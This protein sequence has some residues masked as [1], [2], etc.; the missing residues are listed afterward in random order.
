MNSDGNNEQA[1]TAGTNSLLF[2]LSSEIA[3]VVERAAPSVVRVDDGSRLTA[4]GLVWRQD[5][6]ILTTS[7]GV[8]RDED[9]A[10]ELAGSGESARRLPATLVGRDP[11]TDLAVLRVQATGLPALEQ[12]GFDDA[13]VGHLVLAL[14][15]PGQ[16]G[17]QATLGIV[18]ARQESQ[19]GDT[20]EYILHT[21][22][23]LYPGFSG[24]P[25]VD[26]RGR[27]AGVL[28]R[29]F[30]RGSGIALG[31]PLAAR[32]ADAL[33]TRGTVARG[34]LGVRTQLVALPGPLRATLPL[35]NQERGL[36]VVGVEA[37]SPAENGGLG[38]GDLLLAVNGQAVDDVDTLR[39][40]LRAHLAGETVAL[41]IV[42]GGVRQDLHVTLGA[43]S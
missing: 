37:N 28:N 13:R 6:I 26:M 24:G 17:L 18:S 14:G 23:V 40:H 35:A 1:G 5:G 8:E 34:Y 3:G 42:R 7:H 16:S 38:L 9:L 11:D 39:A 25:L 33:V 32:V 15:R 2:S 27:V 30:G 43:E 41:G 31:T 19:T 4:T 22:A 36:L 29:G 20:P 10:V 12:A 21:D